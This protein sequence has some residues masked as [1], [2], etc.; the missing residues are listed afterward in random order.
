MISISNAS[1]KIGISTTA[2]NKRIAK[3]HIKKVRRGR[4]SCINQEDFEK[5]S[6]LSFHEEETEPDE[7]P[8]KLHETKEN[9]TKPEILIKEKTSRIQFLEE[10]LR[11]KNEQLQN[12]QRLIDQQQQLSLKD[13]NE[14]ESL[15]TRIERLETT[16][17]KRLSSDGILPTQEW[18]ENFKNQVMR[19]IEEFQTI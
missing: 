16:R 10:E 5:I 2:V 14:N 12:M 3:L 11:A 15:I 6:A 8:L 13:K 9:F 17:A 4:F 7:T 1:K 18:L 19:N